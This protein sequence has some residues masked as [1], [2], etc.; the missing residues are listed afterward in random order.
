M[1][2]DALKLILEFVGEMQYGFVAW[3]QIGPIKFILKCLEE[4]Y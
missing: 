2:N 1:S 3:F 4:K